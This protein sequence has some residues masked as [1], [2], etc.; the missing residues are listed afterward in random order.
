[1]FKT[2][3]FFLIILSSSYLNASRLDSLKFQLN[4]STISDVKKVD[5]LNELTTILFYSE[6]ENSKGFSIRSF[7]L[8]ERLD[9]PEGRAETLNNYGYLMMIIGEFDESRD[10][11]RIAAKLF[12]ELKDQKSNARVLVDIAT[13][14]YYQLE[15]DS[16]L[17]YCEKALLELAEHPKNKAIVYNNMGIFSKNGGRYEDAI[18]YYTDALF[19]FKKLKDTALMITAQNNIGS[20]FTQIKNFSKA[21]MYHEKALKNSRITSDSSAIARSLVGLGLVQDN[22]G[23]ITA[24]VNNYMDAIKIFESLKLKKELYSAQYNLANLFFSNKEYNLALSIFRKVKTDFE[25]INAVSEYATTTNAIGLIHYYNDEYDS[26]K[27]YLEEAYSLQ[28]YLDSPDMHKSMLLNLSQL[29]ETTGDFEKAWEINAQYELIKDSLLNLLKE[30]NISKTEAAFQYQSN[31]DEIERRKKDL[32]DEKSTKSS[33]VFKRVLVSI[34]LFVL[35]V[36]AYLFYKLNIRKKRENSELIKSIELS[37]IKLKL[38]K[39]EYND[40]KE[41]YS[42]IDIKKV[43]QIINLSN[44]EFEVFICLAKGFE[45]SEISDKLFISKATINSHCNQ[46]YSKISLKNRGEAGSLARGL[47]L[48]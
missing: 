3:V 46:I 18:E 37:L 38:L 39:K 17:I 1:M 13:S 9:Y 24:A 45:D 25:S 41:I 35:A 12:E 44:R 19:T 4:E 32:E 22:I 33:T 43:E 47:K 34:I 48:V 20:L 10:S 26:A 28:E 2:I 27:V 40:K 21:E 16:A 31:L 23:E 30:E 36:L 7:K 5:I 8:L 15:I 14:F 11:L 6:P 29:Y 42:Q